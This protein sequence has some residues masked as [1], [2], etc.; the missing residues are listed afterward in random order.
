M[1]CLIIGVYLLGCI[2]HF[3]MFLREEDHLLDGWALVFIAFYF[4]LLSWIAVLISW[5]FNTKS[6]PPV[7]LTG[8]R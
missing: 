8:T 2:I 4:S 5:C 7:W 3:R 6:K 1:M